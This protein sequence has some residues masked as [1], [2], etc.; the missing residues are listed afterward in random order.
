MIFCFILGTLLGFV[1]LILGVQWY[2]RGAC[3]GRWQARPVRVTPG[4]GMGR[5]GGTR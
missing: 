2:R 4:L 5:L 1:S 3:R